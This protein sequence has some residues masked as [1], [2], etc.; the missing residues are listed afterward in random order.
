MEDAKLPV[1]I[2]NLDAFFKFLCLYYD[3]DWFQNF[4]KVQIY[5]IWLNKNLIYC[6]KCKCALTRQNPIW[7]TNTQYWVVR[8]PLIP[9]HKHGLSGDRHTWGICR[10]KFC[11][12]LKFFF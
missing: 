7:G 10:N 5:S 12:I 6:K 4:S 11:S 9:L 8:D 1:F 3:R 2:S